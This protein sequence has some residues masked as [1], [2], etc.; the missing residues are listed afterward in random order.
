MAAGRLQ[1]CVPW[2]ASALLALRLM[3]APAAAAESPYLYGIHDRSPS[4]QPFL[5][6]VEIGGATGWVT[7][8]VAIGSNPNDF[9]GG[10]FTVIATV[11]ARNM[12]STISPNSL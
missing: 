1:H 8:T 11:R 7:A 12:H 9:G 6:V 10:D 3:A 5:D 4:P 2:I